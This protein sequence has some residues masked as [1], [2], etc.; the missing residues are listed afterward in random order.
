MMQRQLPG[1]G[2]VAVARKVARKWCHHSCPEMMPPHLP[3][4]DAVQ[5]PGNEEAAIALEKM[6]SH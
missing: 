6:Q 3:G 2:A 1:N 5:L 4:N